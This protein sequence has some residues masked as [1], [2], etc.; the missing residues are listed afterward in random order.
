LAFTG[1][2]LSP[3]LVSG[4]ALIAGGLLILGVTSTRGRHRKR[5]TS[6]S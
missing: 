6:T 3:L 2:S 1:A 5:T 4:G